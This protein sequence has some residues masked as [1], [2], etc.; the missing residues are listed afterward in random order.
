MALYL[1]EED[2]AAVLTMD[3]ALE[4]WLF[5]TTAGPERRGVE[6]RFVHGHLL[7]PGDVART[8]WRSRC[9]QPP[10]DGLPIPRAKIPPG[11]LLSRAVDASVREVAV[12]DVAFP[13]YQGLRNQ[14]S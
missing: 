10:Y 7:K 9:A 11:V 3:I 8:D 2:V 14:P 1:A 13:L 4:E 6:A 5:D 12:Q